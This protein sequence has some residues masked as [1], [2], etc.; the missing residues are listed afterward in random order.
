MIVDLL[1]DLVLTEDLQSSG[2]IL[3]K[4][5]ILDWGV[6]SLRGARSSRLGAYIPSCNS[7]GQE[8]DHIP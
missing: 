3:F 5:S 1:A 7:H 6:S 4:G 8:A 2:S